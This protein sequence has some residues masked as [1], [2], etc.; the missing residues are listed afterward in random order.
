MTKNK[1]V[2]DFNLKVSTHVFSFLVIFRTA[3]QFMF[4]F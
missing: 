1:S 2:G 4:N 3:L